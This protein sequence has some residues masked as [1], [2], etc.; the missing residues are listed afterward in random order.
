M[1]YYVRFNHVFSIIKI[2]NYKK[3]LLDTEVL[4]RPKLVSLGF[5]DTHG[6]LGSVVIIFI[7]AFINIHFIVAI[8]GLIT[9][10]DRLVYFIDLDWFKQ[11]IQNSG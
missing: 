2:Q 5:F 6:Q 1:Y 4:A 8:F 3:Y 10:F 11:V 7:T 9:L